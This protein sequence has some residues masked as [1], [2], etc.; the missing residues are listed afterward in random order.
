MPEIIILINFILYF[1]TTCYYI[2]QEGLTIRSFLWSYLT[3]F[4]LGSVYLLSTGLYFKV[5]DYP[6]FTPDEEISILPYLLNYIFC[7]IFL[8]LT[9]RIKPKNFRLNFCYTKRSRLYILNFLII[10]YLYLLLKILQSIIVYF[11]G[12]G[13]FH[14][15]GKEAQN[16]ILYGGMPWLKYINYLG[17]FVNVVIMPYLIFYCFTIYHKGMMK[18]SIFL[19]IFILYTCNSI[20]VGIVAGSRASMLFGLLNAIFFFVLLYRHIK[21]KSR[22]KILIR[23]IFIMCILLIITHNITKERFQDKE[24]MTISENIARYMGEANLNLT[25]EYFNHLYRH[26]NGRCTFGGFYDNEHYNID[27]VMGVHPEWFKTAYGCFFIDYGPYIPILLILGAILILKCLI[28]RKN[29]RSRDFML[30]FYYYTFCY[31]LPFNLTIEPFDLFMFFSML[32]TPVFL[33]KIFEN[34]QPINLK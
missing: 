23:G 14:E 16:A 27:Y 21:Y 28:R 34:K 1:A 10:E 6:H 29:M 8:S 31:W 30:L 13:N 17:K 19:S 32:I 4:T 20:F 18:Y 2:K 7:F 11:Y 26:T 22:K 9:P 24:T 12:F 15:L 25:Y 33:S 5:M 3:I